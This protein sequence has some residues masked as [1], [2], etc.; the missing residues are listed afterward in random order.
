MALALKIDVVTDRFDAMLNDMAK[1]DPAVEFR[2]IVVQMALRVIQGAANRT[3]AATVQSIQQS[4]AHRFLTRDWVTIEGKKF[5]IQGTGSAGHRNRYPDWLWGG[6]QQLLKQNMADRIARKS[7]SRGLGKQS[8]MHLAEQLGGEIDVPAWVRAASYKGRQY[9][10]DVSH[11]EDKDNGRYGL[12]IVNSS[13]IVGYAGGLA[14]LLG[15]MQAEVGYF[16][17]N[18][19]HGFYLTLARRAQKYP[20]IFVRE[21]GAIA[22]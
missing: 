2:T 15:S 12:T 1:I 22:A 16:T 17:Q 5:L 14:A 4:E 11:Q 10:E 18:M 8:W 9:P 19:A 6:I 7:E 3:Q 20:G 13:P 21:G